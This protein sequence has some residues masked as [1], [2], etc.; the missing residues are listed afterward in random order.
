MDYWEYIMSEKDI[1]EKFIP[2][3]KDYVDD[4]KEESQ[5]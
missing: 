5:I 4:I 1:E 3:L 2:I